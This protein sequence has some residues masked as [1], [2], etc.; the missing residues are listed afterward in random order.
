MDTSKIKTSAQLPD[1]TGVDSLPPV[2]AVKRLAAYMRA[3]RSAADIRDREI[4]GWANGLMVTESG[5]TLSDNTTGDVSTSKHGFAPKA[6]NDATKFLDGA[7]SYTVPDIANLSGSTPTWTEVSSFSNSWVNYGSPHYNAAYTKVNKWVY[8][9]G[10]LKNGSVGSAFTLPTGYRPSSDL[11]LPSTSAGPSVAIV[12]VGSDG[13][14]LL[15]SS[16][17]TRVSID[18]LSFY[19]G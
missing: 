14:V 9:R 10:V 7:G 13:T 6:P 5:L 15:N 1:L 11:R 3:F 4:S 16:D 2:E 19:S 8:L 17:L 18:G 12:T